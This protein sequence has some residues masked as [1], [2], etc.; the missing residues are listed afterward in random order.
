M[1]T[2]PFLPDKPAFPALVVGQPT[3]DYEQGRLCGPKDIEFPL[4]VVVTRSSEKQAQDSLQALLEEV[5]SVFDTNPTLGGRV[6]D[7]RLI[8]AEPQIV[9]TG[10]QDLPGYLVTTIVTA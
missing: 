9:N 5:E 3:F 7:A 2:Y 8:R 4:Y 6:Q 10:G 1:R